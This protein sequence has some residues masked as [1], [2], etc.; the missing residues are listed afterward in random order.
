MSIVLHIGRRTS[1]R[2]WGSYDG[3]H[4]PHSR[5]YRYCQRL[6]ASYYI[7]ESE[8]KH[9]CN[10][11][12]PSIP[13]NPAIVK[14]WPCRES[15][16][17]RTNSSLNPTRE[18][19]GLQPSRAGSRS[20]GTY[21]R[22]PPILMNDTLPIPIKHCRLADIRHG[23]TTR[24][25]LDTLPFSPIPTISKSRTIYSVVTCI[26]RV[27]ST[28]FMDIWGGPNWNTDPWTWNVSY[29]T[30]RNMSNHP[31]WSTIPT[32]RIILRALSNTSTFYTNRHPIPLSLW[33]E[34]KMAENPIIPCP[35]KEIKNCTGGTKT[36]RHWKPMLRLWDDWP[37]TRIST[38]IKPF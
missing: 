7:H 37:I 12:K 1:T 22:A 27:P 10:T 30:T 16:S 33:K 18:T 9:G 21:S 2:Y 32:R 15:A 26:I 38:W 24:S 20:D 8:M 35:M 3:K 4:V 23:G 5:Q 19:V 31:P 17:A 25:I 6:V 14:K 11:N 29:T 13:M 28:R 34:V 36:W